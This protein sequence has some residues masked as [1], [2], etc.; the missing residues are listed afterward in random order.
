MC[1]F[2][3]LTRLK[4]SSFCQIIW[5]F[6]W[7]NHN[8]GITIVMIIAYATGQMDLRVSVPLSCYRTG[9]L[10]RPPLLRWLLSFTLQHV[11]GLLVWYHTT[12]KPNSLRKY[13][14]YY[15]LSTLYYIICLSITHKR[16]KVMLNSRKKTYARYAYQWGAIIIIIW[17]MF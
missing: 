1:W 10:K 8:S 3:C 2:P 9:V 12:P 6:R 17:K 11:Q 4:L 15:T 14:N 16:D 5:N 13:Q 7:G